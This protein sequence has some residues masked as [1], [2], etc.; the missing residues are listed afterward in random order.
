M[1]LI[2]PVLNHL[3][4]FEVGKLKRREERLEG[5]RFVVEREEWKYW[6]L[7]REDFS[8][9][10]WRRLCEEHGVD[11]EVDEVPVTITP[12]GGR[13]VELKRESFLEE[14][15]SRFCEEHDVPPDAYLIRFA[16]RDNRTLIGASRVPPEPLSAL[17]GVYVLGGGSLEELLGALHPNPAT[18][19][20][21]RLGK[22]VH[23]L[24]RENGPLATLVRGGNPKTGRGPEKLSA[25]EHQL[26]VYIKRR[27]SEGAADERI[28]REIRKGS[29]G[30]CGTHDPLALRACRA[31]LPVGHEG[32]KG[33]RVRLAR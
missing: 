29:T 25:T 31:R 16:L 9:E 19:D 6:W 30:G 11:L 24:Q 13:F 27:R 28:L 2:T 20:R 15:W 5:G 12:T 7:G 18:V 23:R 1:R 8:E 32:R 21:E 26:A 33:S 17:V 14:E 3:L 22:I 4:L 10:E